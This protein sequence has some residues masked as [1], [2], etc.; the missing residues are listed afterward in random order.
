VNAEPVTVR[1]LG[2]GFAVAVALLT[3]ACAAGQQAQ[4]ADERATEAGT[5]ATLGSI[6]LRGLLIDAPA[7]TTPYY[8]PGSD[9]SVKLVI[10]N[11]GNQPDRLTGITSSAF[12]DWGAFATPAE[13]DAVEAANQTP[14]TPTSSAASTSA[15]VRT[16]APGSG[17]ASP[18]GSGSRPAG[19]GGAASRTSAKPSASPTRLPTPR[20][21]VTIVAGGRVSWGVPDATGEL[22]VL[23]LTKRLYPGTTVPVTFTFANAGTVTVVVPIALSSSPEFS[24]IPPPPSTGAEG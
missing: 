3:S 12:G 10:V 4:T 6:G 11:S 20:K 24:V 23:H 15:G 17:T 7:G 16:S 14:A 22:L 21:S 18:G 9:A 1:R 5:E 13:A 19:T 2:I 8:R